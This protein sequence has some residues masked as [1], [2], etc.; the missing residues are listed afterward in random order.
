MLSEITF[1]TFLSG[2]LKYIHWSD[3]NFI[4]LASSNSKEVFSHSNTKD[5][6]SLFLK[7][8][9]QDTLYTLQI[10]GMLVLFT[11]LNSAIKWRW[12]K[13]KQ[14]REKSVLLVV[15]RQGVREE[16]WMIWKRVTRG[17]NDKKIFYSNIKYFWESPSRLALSDI[18]NS[19]N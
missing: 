19:L 9:S 5:K 14:D 16:I 12:N 11:E 2:I 15:V 13:I 7:E 3:N 8:V 4:Y 17:L 1:L 18:K 6:M 10:W